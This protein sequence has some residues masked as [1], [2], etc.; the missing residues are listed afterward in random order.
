MVVVVEVVTIAAVVATCSSSGFLSPS[1]TART[2][3]FG[4]WDLFHPETFIGKIASSTV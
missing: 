3:G 1:I 4:A 2:R